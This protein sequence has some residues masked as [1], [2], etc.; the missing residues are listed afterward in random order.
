LTI[1]QLRTYTIRPGAMDQWVAEWTAKVKPLREKLGFTILN[2]WIV[3][4]KSQFVWIMAHDGSKEWAELDAAYFNAPERTAMD[5]DPAR[6]IEKM[7]ERFIE[8]VSFS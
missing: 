2:A 5:P 3:P 8:T 1:T 4:Q 6:H 7:E